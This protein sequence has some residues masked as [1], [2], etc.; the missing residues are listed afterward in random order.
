MENFLDN[1]ERENL[2]KQH[3]QER[4]GRIRDRIKA[5]LLYDKGWSYQQIAEALFISHEAAR[6]H[7]LDY[8]AFRKLKPQNGGSESKLNS[9]QSK[10]LIELLKETIYPSVKDIIALV[11]DEFE[12]SYSVPGM[13]KWLK[14]NNFSY[15]KP[16]IVPGKAN[17]EAQAAW[18]N[19]YNE[20]KNNLLSDEAIFFMDGVH[21]THNTKPSYGWIKKGL[22]KE[23]LSNT[24]R[25]RINITGAIDIISKKVFIR[26]D[27]TL[28][29]TSIICFL[30]ELEKNN[31]S[32]KKIYVYCDNARYYRNKAV[33]LYLATSKISLIFLPPYSPN[34]NPIERL[35]KF[36]NEQ[37]VN[38]HYYEHF[39]EFKA[40][41]IGFLSGLSD[42]P[43]KIFD[44]L[45]K[46]ITDNFRIISAASV[47]I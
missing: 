41:I 35:W 17:G 15:K 20:L 13:T 16:S 34:L 7:T 14:D 4:D 19:E 10:V 27:Q 12:V 31:P 36:M 47:K 25:Q 3:K 33:Q 9:S 26:E 21:P 2:K 45:T 42:P 32:K 29:A 22:R 11:W 46:R 43:K 40:K 8:E 5:V 18:I 23:I 1:T 6:Q 38:N 30:K 28:E 37:V 39:K 44:L 24:G